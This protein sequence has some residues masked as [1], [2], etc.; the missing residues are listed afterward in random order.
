MP[1][2]QTLQEIVHDF[3]IIAEEEVRDNQILPNERYTPA[4]LVE[5]SPPGTTLEQVCS[6]LSTLTGFAPEI[7]SNK[8]E[9]IVVFAMQ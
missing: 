8:P 1:A 3:L 5:C 7:F 2:K 6:V 9:Q 4:M